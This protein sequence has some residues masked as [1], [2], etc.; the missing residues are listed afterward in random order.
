MGKRG[1]GSGGVAIYE[2]HVSL[3]DRVVVT[4]Y[5]GRR[6]TWVVCT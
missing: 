5:L 6:L 1:S 3:Y 2:N 4:R